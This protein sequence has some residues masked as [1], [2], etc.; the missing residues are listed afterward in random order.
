MFSGIGDFIIICMLILLGVVAALL[1]QQIKL[2]II[3][4]RAFKAWMMEL[5]QDEH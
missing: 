3:E 5:K 2:M 4:N 1:V